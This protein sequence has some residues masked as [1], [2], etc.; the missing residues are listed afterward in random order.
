M[1]IVFVS[2][3]GFLLFK[4]PKVYLAI[5]LNFGLI[6]F[7]N[8]K[9]HGARARKSNKSLTQGFRGAIVARVILAAVMLEAALAIPRTGI[10]ITYFFYSVL[11]IYIYA[12]FEELKLIQGEETS[13]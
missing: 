4:S 7:M 12:I 2:L 13:L 10:A 5:A 11:P 1:L 3:G 6:I 9:A 8:E